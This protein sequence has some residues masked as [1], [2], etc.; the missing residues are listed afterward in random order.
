MLEKNAGNGIVFCAPAILGAFRRKPPSSHLQVVVV[1]RQLCVIYP[2]PIRTALHV[3][4]WCIRSHVQVAIAIVQG[5]PKK[6]E[7]KRNSS[8]WDA[9]LERQGGGGSE[10]QRVFRRDGV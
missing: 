2:R 5:R 6:K 1:G 3:Q 8:S 9:A 10:A 4:V 7:T